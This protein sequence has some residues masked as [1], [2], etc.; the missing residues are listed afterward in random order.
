MQNLSLCSAPFAFL[1]VI[2]VPI[3]LEQGARL[4]TSQTVISFH[5]SYAKYCVQVQRYLAVVRIFQ[6]Y[7]PTLGLLIKLYHAV[8]AIREISSIITISVQKTRR[9]LHC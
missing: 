9:V 5:L 8:Y 3:A 7:F 4:F 2:L 6:S 1:F